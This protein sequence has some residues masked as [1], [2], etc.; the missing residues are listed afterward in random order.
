MGKF[1]IV[2]RQDRLWVVFRR[3]VIGDDGV[4]WSLGRC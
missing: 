1:A 2:M 4:S 3:R